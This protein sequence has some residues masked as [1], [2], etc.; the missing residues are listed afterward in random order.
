M[1]PCERGWN[2][3]C[4]QDGGEQGRQGG[5][6]ICRGTQEGFQVQRDM[7]RLCLGHTG[8]WLLKVW[9]REVEEKWLCRD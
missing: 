6:R 9:E 7:G 4:A 3:L 5:T 2:T 8:R 1:R